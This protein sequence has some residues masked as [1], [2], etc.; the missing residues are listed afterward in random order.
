MGLVLSSVSVCE[1]NS[2]WEGVPSFA[3]LSQLYRSDSQEFKP[4]ISTGR[5]RTDTCTLHEDL[6]GREIGG[7]VHTRVT[8]QEGSPRGRVKL[9]VPCMSRAALGRDP[10]HVPPV[11]KIP[12]LP[13]SPYESRAHP[14]FL[15]YSFTEGC[16][17]REYHLT[18]LS[19][20]LSQNTHEFTE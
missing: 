1:H 12:V 2:T 15:C 16:T 6:S 13:A 19:S 18:A 17:E 4:W 3:L 7:L 14:R 10:L 9:R 20:K 5:T 8:R 11:W